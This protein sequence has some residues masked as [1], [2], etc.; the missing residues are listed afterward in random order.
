M[1]RCSTTNFQQITFILWCHRARYWQ[2]EPLR[3]R[4]LQNCKKRLPISSGTNAAVVTLTLPA[5]RCWTSLCGM[6]SCVSHGCGWRCWHGHCRHWEMCLR[7]IPFVCEYRSA[8]PLWQ[9]KAGVCISQSRILTTCHMYHLPLSQPTIPLQ[10]GPCT[11]P[12][13]SCPDW[14]GTHYENGQCSPEGLKTEVRQVG[15]LRKV[16]RLRHKAKFKGSR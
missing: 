10:W 11:A 2:S 6:H 8:I 15:R 7:R 4:S 5:G 12:P 1:I 16:I 9:H 3:I 14:L 13:H